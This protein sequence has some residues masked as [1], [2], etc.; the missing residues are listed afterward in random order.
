[1]PP[2][3]LSGITSASES[4][5]SNGH[6]INGMHLYYVRELKDR[7][8]QP[9]LF[10]IDPGSIAVSSLAELPIIQ[11]TSDELNL[12]ATQDSLAPI[13]PSSICSNE[14][15]DAV[16]ALAVDP[17]DIS[18]WMIL[19]EEVEQGRGGAAKIDDTYTRF[20]DQFPRAARFW[21]KLTSYYS[22]NAESTTNIEEQLQLYNNLIKTFENC[23]NKCRSVSLWRACLACVKRTSVDQ[24]IAA[25][26]ASNAQPTQQLIERYYEERKKTEQA[27]EAALDN[28]GMAI[29]AGELWRY[30][31]TNPF[32]VPSSFVIK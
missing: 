15:T 29:D 9:Y 21:M 16:T 14:Y 13:E 17:W 18:S 1:M 2:P 4:I 12:K 23:L 7:T 32:N 27:Y 11:S 30:A 19:L 20:L 8:F 28:V 22:R 10:L 25:A 26:K 6:A 24:V 3:L 31:Y 5:P